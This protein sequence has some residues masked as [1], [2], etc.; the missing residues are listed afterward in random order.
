MVLLR[1]RQTRTC[2]VMY[3][4]KGAN[5][6]AQLLGLTAMAFQFAIIFI[7]MPDQVRLL[8]KT[9]DSGTVSVR[10]NVLCLASCIFWGAY[11]FV[12]ADWW[13]FFPQIPATVLNLAIVFLCL[14]YKKENMHLIQTPTNATLF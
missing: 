10:L 12:R 13:L 9:R 5:M 8:M 11:G 6:P 14:R 1:V 7:G 3:L 4:E 2:T